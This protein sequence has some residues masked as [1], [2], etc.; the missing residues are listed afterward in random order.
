MKVVGDVYAGICLYYSLI[1]Y[2]IRQQNGSKIVQLELLKVTL[3]G[4][5][6]IEKRLRRVRVGK[7]II[8]ISGEASPVWGKWKSGL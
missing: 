3:D 4:T 2:L 8:R 5:M 6:A 7:R 1:N